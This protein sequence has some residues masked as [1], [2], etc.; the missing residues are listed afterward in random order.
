MRSLGFLVFLLL[1]VI[2]VIMTLCWYL[3]RNLKRNS[4]GFVIVRHIKDERT[5]QYWY[6][7]YQSIRKHYPSTPIVVI[8]DDS[9]PSFVDQELEKNLFNCRIIQSELP[10]RGEIL[11]YYYFWKHKWFQKAVV[12]HNS[13]FL[14]QEMDFH[15]CK[16]VKFLWH[17]EDKQYDNVERET[18][19]L[20]DIGSQYVHL[21]ESKEYWKG[22]FGVMS[23]IDHDFM[24][25]IADIFVL[26][27]TIKSRSDRC[28]LERVFAV[29]CFYHDPSLMRNISFMGDIHEYA[30]PWGYDFQTYQEEEDK[31]RTFP[32]LVKVWTGR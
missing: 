7:S 11:G 32:S 5:S 19:F 25:K 28:C 1:V 21:Y 2:I 10:K 24:C 22:C 6:R 4:L 20:R 14:H 29:M 12:L 3:N 17:I 13:V 16:N 26:L 8:D 18:F 27:P 9:N 31:Q 23:V 30:L 15:S